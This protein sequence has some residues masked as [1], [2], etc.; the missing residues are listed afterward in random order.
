MRARQLEVFTA[1]M[2]AGTV[3]GAAR[4]LNISQPALSQILAHTEDELGFALFDR[5]RGRLVPTPEAREILT[6]AERVFAGLE[7][8]RRKTADLRLGRAGLVRIAASAPPGM[9]I[10]P[11]ALASFRARWPEVRLRSHIAPISTILRMLREG[12]AAL[13]LALDDRASPDLKAEVLGHAPFVCLMPEG[14]PLAARDRLTL[15]DLA[16]ETLISYR[17][18][19]RPAEEIAR[20]ARLA[21][22]ELS[23]TLEIDVSLSALGFV[24]QGLGVALVDGLLPWSQFAGL[25]L[26]P[27]EDAPPLPVAL[28]TNPARPL[29][30][31]ETAMEAHLRAAC[32][33]CLR[34]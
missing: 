5:I 17:A 34:P 24:Q 19:T 30:Q 2:R 18:G 31:A 9:A 32:A 27:V 14:H 10:V 13:A 23:P 22:V 21:G 4:L 15:A 3:T 20:A 6:D 7:G 8:L 25:A 29:S 16:G 12:D 11:R 1:V 26:R 33:G 28:L